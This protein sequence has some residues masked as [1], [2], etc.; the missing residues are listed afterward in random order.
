MGTGSL[1]RA[2]IC[3]MHEL[4]PAYRALKRAYTATILD[5]RRKPVKSRSGLKS[6]WFAPNPLIFPAFRGH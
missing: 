5:A 4:T 6:S 3:M 2:S 1:S